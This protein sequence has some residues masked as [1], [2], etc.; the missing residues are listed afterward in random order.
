MPPDSRCIHEDPTLSNIHLACGKTPQRPPPS[1]WAVTEAR[2][3]VGKA[4]G[5]SHKECRLSHKAS[6][7][8]FAFIQKLLKLSGARDTVIGD[9]LESGAPMGISSPIPPGGWFPTQAHGAD[10][11]P[12]ELDAASH[13]HG[14]HPSF[15][16]LHGEDEAPAVKLVQEHVDA[17]FWDGLRFKGRC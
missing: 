10:L 12:D 9:W 6:G 2:R 8:K 16:A 17:G 11:T 7:W 5:L 15:N 4:I 3:K 1:E 14:N 13:Y